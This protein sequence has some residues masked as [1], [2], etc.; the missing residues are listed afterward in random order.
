MTIVPQE[1]ILFND[2]IS[3]NIAYPK[4]EDYSKAELSSQQE[5]QIYLTL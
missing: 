2:D 1:P 4:I 3:Y 5:R